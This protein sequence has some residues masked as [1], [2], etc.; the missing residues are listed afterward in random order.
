MDVNFTALEVFQIAEQIEQNA[1]KF[2]RDAAAAAKNK[3]TA[4]IFTIL[5]DMEDKHKNIFSEMLENY[6]QSQEDA[7][8][9][10]PDN[11]MMYYMKG[12]AL[13][14]GW[15]GKAAPEL[16]FSGNET[17]A[18]I[19]KTALNAEQ[20]SINFYLGIKE[21]VKSKTDKEKIENIIKEEM[22][23]IVYLQ[24]SLEDTKQ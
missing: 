3:D 17:P 12:M 2:Y 9:F 14:S 19:L 10:D 8:I 24:K 16:L 20:N 13:N 23:H 21:L 18:E 5:A 7:N 6:K 22:S 4:K 15:E 1:S 11:E